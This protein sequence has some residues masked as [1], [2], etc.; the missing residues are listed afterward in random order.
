MRGGCV[1]RA[2]AFNERAHALDTATVAAAA[3]SHLC[4]RQVYSGLF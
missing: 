3:A 4:Q 2:G 1:T